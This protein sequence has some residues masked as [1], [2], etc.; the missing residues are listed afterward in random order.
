MSR[1]T[2]S[3]RQKRIVAQRASNY[4]EYCRSP[5]DFS[6]TS[7]SVDHVVPRVL[8]GVDHLDNLAFSCQG[9][10]N[11]KHTAVSAIDPITSNETRLYNP[12]QDQWSEHFAW[13]DDFTEIIG[14][15]PIGRATISRLRLN[16]LGLLNQRRAL[17]MIG[18]HPPKL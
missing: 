4:C 1:T 7:F 8:G 12:R 17:H 9:C 14:L 13:S 16:R 3:A 5:L 18:E 11:R 2:I 6:S 15:T 10:N